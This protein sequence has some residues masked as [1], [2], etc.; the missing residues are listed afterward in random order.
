MRTKRASMTDVALLL[1]AP[2]RAWAGHVES[3]LK[4]ALDGHGSVTL[5]VLGAELGEIHEGRTCFVT[6]VASCEQAP[7]AA[8]ALITSALRDFQ[9][10]RRRLDSGLTQPVVRPFCR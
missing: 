7:D 1:E 6:G 2:D 3:L 9:L 4:R 5:G 10:E 8:L